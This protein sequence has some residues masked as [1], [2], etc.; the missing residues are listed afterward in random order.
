[1]GV[2][3][4]VGMCFVLIL[5]VALYMLCAKQALDALYKYGCVD[6]TES[7]DNVH[8]FSGTFHGAATTTNVASKLNKFS[9]SRTQ[10]SENNFLKRGSPFPERAPPNPDFSFEGEY[11]FT[12]DNNP[13]LV[14]GGGGLFASSDRQLSGEDESGEVSMEEVSSPPTGWS[15]VVC[16]FLNSPEDA[17]CSMCF[18]PGPPEEERLETVKV[19]QPKSAMKSSSRGGGSTFSS[20]SGN[21]TPQSKNMHTPGTVRAPHSLPG[22]P[23]SALQSPNLD[24]FPAPSPCS[25]V[26]AGGSGYDS[27]GELGRS[28]LQ[29]QRSML[30]TN[31]LPLNSNLQP[32]FRT[33]LSLKLNLLAA[34]C[35]HIIGEDDD[36][37]NTLTRALGGVSGAEHAASIAAREAKQHNTD[38]D[39]YNQSTL[40]ESDNSVD[41]NNIQGTDGGEDDEEEDMMFS[42]PPSRGVMSSAGKSTARRHPNTKTKLSGIKEGKALDDKVH[43]VRQR[44]GSGSGSFQEHDEEGDDNDDEVRFN[45]GRKKGPKSVDLRASCCALLGVVLDKQS[46]SEA[47]IQWLANALR[48]D[49]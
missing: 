8:D 44:G 39:L 3:I 4:D 20:F 49:P 16:T 31:R 42:P 41:N 30:E 29:Q 18:T 6:E 47:A 19:M 43:G 15:C 5:S 17:T 33:D 27:S 34:Q 10:C 13:K 28:R 26:Q 12:D 9:P 32:T 36:C 48:I 24:P 21:G 1:V 11:S 45:G 22:T 23:I 37:V 7:T 25:D 40:R 2:S 35:M 38:I 14:G 46:K